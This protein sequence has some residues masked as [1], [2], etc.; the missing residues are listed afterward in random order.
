MGRSFG[1]VQNL[2]RSFGA[3]QVAAIPDGWSGHI[4][5]IIADVEYDVE[6][7]KTTVFDVQQNTATTYDIEKT[8]SVDPI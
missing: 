7:S 8:Q 2:G 3:V 5:R 4:V 6:Q 1:A